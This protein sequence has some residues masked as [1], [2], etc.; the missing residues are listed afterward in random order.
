MESQFNEIL[1]QAKPHLQTLRN[2]IYE[3]RLLNEER[4]RHE[5]ARFD[6]FYGIQF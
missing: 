5:L 4:E 2:K 3:E 1:E 6:E